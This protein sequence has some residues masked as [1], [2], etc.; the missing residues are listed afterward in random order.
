MALLENHFKPDIFIVLVADLG[1][2]F[3]LLQLL[4]FFLVQ[5][6]SLDSEP[7]GQLVN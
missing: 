6:V 3:I 1:L 4:K 5:T 7:D 2:L